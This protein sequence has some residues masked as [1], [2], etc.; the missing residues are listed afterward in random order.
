MTATV[1]AEETYTV[2]TP[3]VVEAQSPTTGF[4]VVFED[5]G[6]TGYLY[7]LDLGRG[8]NRICDALQIYTVAA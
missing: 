4:G 2:R 7:A 1:V 8:D 5:D 3:T 6:T